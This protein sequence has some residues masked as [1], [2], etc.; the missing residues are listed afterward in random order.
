MRFTTALSA[1]LI[2]LYPYPYESLGGALFML[3]VAGAV[4]A[5]VYGGMQEDKYKIWKYN[6]DN[7]PD[8][9]SKRR[10]DLIGV[11][12]GV[13]MLLA[14]A[15]YVGLGLTR[16]AWGTAWWLFAVGGILCGVV[17]VALNPYKGED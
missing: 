8:P 9:E 4:F 13:I 17:S 10:L 6:R 15:V 5:F 12:C 14:T 7:N 3:L 1:K 2:N 11:A 16:N